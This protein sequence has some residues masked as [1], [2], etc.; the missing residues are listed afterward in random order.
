MHWRRPKNTRAV[1]K[2]CIAAKGET[3]FLTQIDE[4]ENEGRGRN[5]IYR[6]N[7]ELAKKSF[8]IL[9]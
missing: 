9:T 6:V 1:S 2:S 8:A 3:A 5:W 7:G 4:L